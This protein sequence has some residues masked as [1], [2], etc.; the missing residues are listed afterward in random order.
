MKVTSRGND[1]GGTY[2]PFS[3]DCSAFLDWVLKNVGPVMVIGIST[4][5]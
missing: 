2:R 5:I 3:L 1:P 4:E